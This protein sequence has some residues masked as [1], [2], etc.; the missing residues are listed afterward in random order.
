MSHSNVIFPQRI[1][2]WGEF[3]GSFKTSCLCCHNLSAITTKKL[4]SV[5]QELSMLGGLDPAC[6][7]LEFFNGAIFEKLCWLE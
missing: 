5:K 1:C 3:C 4:Y 6:S 7:I 2:D